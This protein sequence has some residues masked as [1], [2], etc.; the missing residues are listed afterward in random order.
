MDRHTL[1]WLAFTVAM[2]ALSSSSGATQQHQMH[3]LSDDDI[4]KS[5]RLAAPRAIVDHATI[6]GM[7]DAGTRR[8]I[9][10]GSNNFTCMADD[11]NSPGPEPMCADQNGMKW[12][13]AWAAHRDP[14]ADAVGFIYMLDG[15]TDAS[16]TDPYA[17]KP[18][19]NNNWIMT[20]PHVMVVGAKELMAGY[21]RLPRPDTSQPY[22]MWAGTP[23]EHLM[24]PMR[25]DSYQRLSQQQ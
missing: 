4:I 9:R 8:L 1:A 21:P 25:M 18:E 14:P 20:G 19:P 12:I 23:Y 24:I 2:A 10:Q 17:S 13:E 22:V 16:N 3:G 5:L 15:G 6:M 11:P 7:A